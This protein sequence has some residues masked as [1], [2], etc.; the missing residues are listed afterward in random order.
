MPYDPTAIVTNGTF[1]VEK[2]HAYSPLYMSATLCMAYG[3]S[4]AAFAAVFVHTFSTLHIYPPN[5]F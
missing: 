5:N 4:F 3:V 2:Y 1:N